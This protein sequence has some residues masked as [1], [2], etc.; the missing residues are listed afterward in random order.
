MDGVAN[1]LATDVTNDPGTVYETYY[2]DL[3]QDGSVDSLDREL[4]YEYLTDSYKY[5]LTTSQMKLAD[6]NN[7]GKVTLNNL[8]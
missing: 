8:A 2:G 1:C 6:L 4:L 7:D 3:N 5:A